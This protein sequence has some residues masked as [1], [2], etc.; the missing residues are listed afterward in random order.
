MEVSPGLSLEKA[1]LKFGEA[2]D[3]PLVTFSDAHTLEDIGKSFTGF[4]IEEAN[5]KEIRKALSGE[6]GRK[7]VI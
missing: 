3:F 4:L 2:F 7:V 5:I 1:Q 6:D